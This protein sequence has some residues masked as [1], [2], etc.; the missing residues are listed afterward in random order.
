MS[1]NI[2]FDRK[3]LSC[4]YVIRYIL[5][6]YFKNIT[7]KVILIKKNYIIILKISITGGKQKGKNIIWGEM[8][9]LKNLF[10]NVVNVPGEDYSESYELSMSSHAFERQESRFVDCAID[11]FSKGKDELAKIPVG[12]TFA[13][14]DSDT[15]QIV[16]MK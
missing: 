1:S 4:F 2:V 14:V 10:T 5:Y 3:N 9:M 12:I 16:I 15:E 6:I 7:K 11:L 13:I 8:K